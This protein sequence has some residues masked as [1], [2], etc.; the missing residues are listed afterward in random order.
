MNPTVENLREILLPL[1]NLSDLA[2][3]HLNGREAETAVVDP[4]HI[5]MVVLRADKAALGLEQEEEIWGLNLQKIL[6][7]LK[8]VSPSKQVSIE[9]DGHALVLRIGALERRIAL[10]DPSMFSAQKVPSLN[11]EYSTEVPRD[12]L[13]KVVKACWQLSD[14][15]RLRATQKGLVA[16]AWGDEND[17][18]EIRLGGPVGT[19][20]SEYPV[21]YLLKTL[22]HA[23]AQ[24]IRLEFGHKFPLRLRY[25][26]L[27][28]L[29]EVEYLL[30]PRV[31]GD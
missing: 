20:V 16:E 21:D 18:V 17:E 12:E 27:G 14:T 6:G 8:L 26:V 3:L 25:D 9:R 11:F 13:L 1:Y 31:G 19:V 28:G 7:F 29:G 15:I 22:K 5:A 10:E 24:T 4:A 2:A 30:A 23:K